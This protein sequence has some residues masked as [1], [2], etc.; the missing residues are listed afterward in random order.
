MIFIVVIDMVG[1]HV[2]DVFYLTRVFSLENV[3]PFPFR[4]S[5]KNKRHLNYF[6]LFPIRLVTEKIGKNHDHFIKTS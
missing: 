6:I 2:Y 1:F 3:L 5:N 4:I